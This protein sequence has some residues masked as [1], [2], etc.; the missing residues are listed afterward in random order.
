MHVHFRIRLDNLFL[1]SSPSS[2]DRFLGLRFV[3][4]LMFFVSLVSLFV[5]SLHSSLPQR[6]WEPW[7]TL[8]GFLYLALTAVWI[9]GA[10]ILFILT[11]STNIIERKL[12]GYRMAFSL[13]LVVCAIITGVEAC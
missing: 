5:I 6:D 13:W 9:G 7:H 12:L 1:L 3:N 8:S 11:G 2:R 10:T 4:S